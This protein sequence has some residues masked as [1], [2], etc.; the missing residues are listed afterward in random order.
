MRF[1]SFAVIGTA[2]RIAIEAVVVGAL[3]IGMAL[4]LLPIVTHLM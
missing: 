1:G 4:C 2:R 3:L